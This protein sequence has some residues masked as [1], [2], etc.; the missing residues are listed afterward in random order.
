M[1]VEERAPSWPDTAFGPPVLGA[2]AGHDTTTTW[3]LHLSMLEVMMVKHDDVGL[4]LRA[5]AVG[6]LSKHVFTI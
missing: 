6:S 1:S 3:S 4:M 5:D 2:T